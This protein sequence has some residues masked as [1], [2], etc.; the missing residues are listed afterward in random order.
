MI[1]STGHGLG[2]RI[3]EKP[4]IS[5]KS[6]E[7]LDKGMVFTIEPGMYLK[8]YGIRIE[9]TILLRQKPIILTKSEKRLINHEI[10]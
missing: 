2:K 5:I 10:Q 3:H 1:H 6:N 4:H 7:N 9:D 8:S